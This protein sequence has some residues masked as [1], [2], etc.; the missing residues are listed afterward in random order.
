MLSTEETLNPLDRIFFIDS[1]IQY[2]KDEELLL[3]MNSDQFNPTKLSYTK[4]TVPKFIKSNYN[5]SIKIKE[6]SPNKIIIETNLDSQNFIGLS[7]IYYPN[8]EI[9]N[10][11]IEIIQINGLLRGIV[12]PIGKNTIIMQLN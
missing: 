12:A 6:W 8:W 10:H 11:D 4:S 1:L 2:K 5:S 7:E 9:T 3:A